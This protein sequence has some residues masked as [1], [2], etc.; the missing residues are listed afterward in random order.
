MPSAD[1]SDH[2]AYQSVGSAAFNWNERHVALEKYGRDVM[3]IIGGA[4]L[5]LIGEIQFVKHPAG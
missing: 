4:P 1:G 2:R 3:T 5:T